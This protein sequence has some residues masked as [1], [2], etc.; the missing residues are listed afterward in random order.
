MVTNLE[1][2]QK[3][4][5]KI[6]FAFYTDRRLFCSELLFLA[7]KV[8]IYIHRFIRTNRRSKECAPSEQINALKLDVYDLFHYMGRF[9][10]VCGP[11][12]VSGSQA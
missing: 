2:T 1:P 5:L 6:I 7:T 4:W 8:N 9:V 3:L 12:R 11:P 10:L